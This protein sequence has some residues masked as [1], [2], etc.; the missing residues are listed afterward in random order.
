MSPAEIYR[1]LREIIESN[2]LYVEVVLDH[3]WIFLRRPG[4]RISVF[5]DEPVRARSLGKWMTTF[6]RAD[7]VPG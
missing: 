4:F 5:G 7:V 6:D 3:A 2:Q 1:H